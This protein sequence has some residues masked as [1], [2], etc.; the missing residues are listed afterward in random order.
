MDKIKNLEI[1]C[2]LRKIKT[3]E[4]DTVGVLDLSIL[5]RSLTDYIPRDTVFIDGYYVYGYNRVG[6]NVL[7]RG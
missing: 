5:E 7:L 3:R 6:F 1:C 2:G 4:G